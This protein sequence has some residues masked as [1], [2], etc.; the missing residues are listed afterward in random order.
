MFLPLNPQPFPPDG[1]GSYPDLVQ[2]S[3][4]MRGLFAAAQRFYLLFQQHTTPERMAADGYWAG[5]SC[6]ACLGPHTAVVLP[7][8]R[9]Y[10]LLHQVHAPDFNEQLEARLRQVGSRA[11]GDD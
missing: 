7:D 6:L 11:L 9:T 10:R 3:A 2:G 4:V 1:W 5:S 8:G